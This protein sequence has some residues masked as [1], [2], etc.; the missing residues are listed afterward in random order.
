[1][2]NEIKTSNGKKQVKKTGRWRPCCNF[3]GCINRADKGLC[4]IHNPERI[5]YEK[6]FASH[7]KS[8]HWHST[9]NGN[10]NPRDVFKS[11]S[12]K[13]WFKC[14]DE[15]CGHDFDA[16]LNSINNNCWCP[17]CASPPKRLCNDTNCKP[18]KEKS[19]ASNEKSEHLHPTKNGNLNPRDVFKS[20]SGKF[21]FKCFDEKC[22]HDFDASLAHISRNRWC[23]YC[24]V[25][26]KKLCNDI[27]CKPCN[28][29]SF[30]SYEKSKD[31]HPTKN[32]VVKPRDVFKSSDEKYW[33]KCSDEKCGH[34]FDERLSHITNETCWCPYCS[35][36]KLCNDINCRSCKEKSFVSNEKSKHWHPTKNGNVK[37]RDVFKSSNKIFWFKCSDEK[38]GHDFDIILA[39]ITCA[40]HWCSY[41]A[42]QNL[43]NDI[44]CKPCNE[45]SFASHEKSE[46][47]HPTKNG[48]VKPCDVFKSSGKKYWFKCYDVNCGHDFNASLNSIDNRNSWCP[49]C[50]NKTE[51]K[52][53][54]YL[55][56]M[57]EELKI[58]EIFKNY[59]PKWADLRETHETFYEY[60]FYI[61]LMNGVKIIIEIDGPQHYMQV[62][63][64]SDP[65]HNQIRDKIK[66]N[67]AIKEQ[68]NMIR[69]NQEDVLHDKNNWEKK[70]K[71]IIDKIETID[72]IKIYDYADGERYNSQND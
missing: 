23:P 67:L 31:W 59:R 51:K 71:D 2:E 7:E 56:D 60:D 49:H 61:V 52:F 30:A 63:N 66:E 35:N 41:C 70:F 42:H 58:K 57:K 34:D 40:N 16:S 37:P 55:L 38:C 28:E 1:M 15:K 24:A 22:G 46:H 39:S 5:P 47:W 25:P 3:E 64:W 68:I 54:E 6:S 12:G 19:F 32:G 18:C 43:C 9:K 17:Y 50:K 33:F 21:W 48:D 53:Y 29:K 14:F 8:E 44:D 27:N 11:S 4:S 36:H 10:V 69:L 45:K 13:F 20:S 72:K 65:R 62:S 26:S